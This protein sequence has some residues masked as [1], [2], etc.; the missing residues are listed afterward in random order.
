MAQETSPENYQFKYLD[1]P[2]MQTWN[3]VIESDV[4]V[5]DWAINPSLDLFVY[6]EG[7][8]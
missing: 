7:H 1:S 3:H 2:S 8:P 6:V 5:M 4:G